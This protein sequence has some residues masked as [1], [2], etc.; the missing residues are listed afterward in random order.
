M[1]T[2]LNT[3]KL[4]LCVGVGGEGLKS[5]WPRFGHKGSYRHPLVFAMKY[6]LGSR[7]LELSPE[8]ILR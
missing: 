2:Y 5:I 7:A 1:S 4:N 3:K 8:C 6:W